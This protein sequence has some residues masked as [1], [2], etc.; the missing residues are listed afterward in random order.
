MM[1]FAMLARS[2]ELV[3]TR[4]AGVSVWRL[5]SPVLISATLLGIFAFAVYNPLASAFTEKFDVLEQRYFDRSS[6]RLA[7]SGKGLWL[8]Q[9]GEQGQ[10][11]IRAQHADSTIERLE[12]VT[13]F[14]FDRMDRLYRRIN[15]ETAILGDQVWNLTG[16][17]RWNLSDRQ[18][19]DI[20]TSMAEMRA[21]SLPEMNIPTELTAERIQ[22]S[23]AAPETI[24][25]WELPE[26]IALLDE[27]G[28]SSS[29]HRLHWL[30]LAAQP[31]VFVAMVLIG[32]VFSM[33]HQRFGGLGYMA[34]ATVIAGFGYFFLS[35]I[36]G[37]LGASGAIPVMLSGLGPPLA[38]VL[39]SLG[40]LLHLED[41]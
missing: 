4:A 26:F 24:S 9:G 11:V 10:T 28:F 27:S 5:L 18:E 21:T 29:R 37:A 23:F 2:S 35:D 32:A 41:G 25:F 22:D 7:V 13:I 8:R 33:R 17:L 14:Q 40:L 19:T 39:L 1:T 16:V 30:R 36:A 12:D 34:L 15:A 38:A 31:A 20:E 6:S 3:V